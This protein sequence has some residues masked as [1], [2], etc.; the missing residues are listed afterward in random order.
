MTLIGVH[1]GLSVDHLVTEGA[2]AQFD[3]LGGPALFAALGA[4]LVSGSRVRVSCEL[5][6]DEPRFAALFASLGIE[7]DHAGRTPTA[8]RLWILNSRAGRRIVRLASGGATELSGDDPDERDALPTPAPGFYGELDGLLESSPEVR[9]PDGAARVIG[10]DPHQTL[11]ASDGL[12]YLAD[13]AFGAQVLLPS[14]VQLRL[15]A[16]DPREA[17]RG[18]ASTL[19]IPV[20][21]RLDA[22]GCYVVI[23]DR[24]WSVA[25]SDVE[26]V[27]TTGAGDASAAAVVAAMAM[28]ADPIEA[29]AFGTSAARIALQGWGEESLA[30]ATPFAA[31]LPGITTHKEL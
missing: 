3:H 9:A 7:T 20:V 27:E 4:R 14:R 13:V 5:P 22:E 12:A 18:L 11:V 1:G 16:Q 29:A 31:P 19:G 2:G 10:I 6:D 8:M 15:L 25:D 28:G 30:A 23:G 17:A 26:V 24:A 21:A